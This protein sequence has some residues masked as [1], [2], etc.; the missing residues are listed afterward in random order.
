[1]QQVLEWFLNSVFLGRSAFGVDAASR[2]YFDKSGQELTLA[3]S[4]LLVALMD[5]PALNPLDSPAASLELKQAV[6]DSLRQSGAIDAQEYRQAAAEAL[7]LRTPDQV[8]SPVIPAYVDKIAHQLEPILGAN[9]LQ[10]G[11]LTVVTTLDADL[12]SQL[13][14][15]AKTQLFRIENSSISGVAAESVNCPASLLLPTQNFSAQS[16]SG[17]AA[18]GLIV[19]PKTGQVLAYLSPTSQFGDTLSDAPAQPG[20][21]LSPVVALAGFARGASPSSLLW[22]IPASLPADLPGA[23]NPG[24]AFHGPVSLRSAVANDYIVPIAQLAAQISPAVTWQM[25]GSLGLNGSVSSPASAEAL[26]QGGEVSLLEIA[27]VYATLANAGTRVGIADPS[28]GKLDLNLVL[29]V[30]TPS[31]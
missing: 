15:T 14:C 6:L 26:F 25:G 11:G 18:R 3:E 13:E 19:D 17:L 1:R 24:G 27:Q 22:D 28:T 21:L 8:E 16:L 30:K 4:A 20:S 10:Q 31:Q 2:L 9:R 23:S 29:T 7:P 5:A 12:Q